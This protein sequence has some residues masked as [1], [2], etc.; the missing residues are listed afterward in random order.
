MGDASEAS[1]RPPRALP[2]EEFEPLE[3]VKSTFKL[4]REWTHN[5]GIRERDVLMRTLGLTTGFAGEE[6]AW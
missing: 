2:T 4:R 1:H 6:L 3:R 5:M